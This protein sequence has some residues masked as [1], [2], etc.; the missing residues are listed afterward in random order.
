MAVLYIVFARAHFFVANVWDLAFCAICLG[1]FDHIAEH[2]TTKI[3]NWEKANGLYIL[4]L[5]LE[6]WPL[7]LS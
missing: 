5:D 6:A 1:I 3:H 7:F 2:N 4:E